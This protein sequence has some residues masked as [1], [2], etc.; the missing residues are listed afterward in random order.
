[1]KN[2]A[3]ALRRDSINKREFKVYLLLKSLLEE[4]ATDEERAPSG[5]DLLDL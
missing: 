1:M 2:C 3:S 5:T 4:H